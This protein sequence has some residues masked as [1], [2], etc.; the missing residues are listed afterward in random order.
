MQVKVVSTGGKES[1]YSCESYDKWE[2]DNDIAVRIQPSGKVIKIP[3]DGNVIFVESGEGHTINTWRA[4]G[5]SH[6]G[7]KVDG[8]FAKKAEFRA[9]EAEKVDGG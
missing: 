1:A 9:L 3:R 8:H 5:E 4:D 7:H 2:E 6:R